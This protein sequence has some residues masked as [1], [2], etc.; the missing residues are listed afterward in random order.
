M[1]VKHMAPLRLL[2]VCTCLALPLGGCLQLAAMQVAGSLVGA[3]LGGGSAGTP[4]GGGA[5]RA[6]RQPDSSIQ[7]SP[8]V[9][10]AA[11]ALEDATAQ[12][13]LA[14]CRARLPQ[15]EPAQLAAQTPIPGAAQAPVPGT[16]PGA[17]PQAAASDAGPASDR[18]GGADL[19]G[20]DLGGAELRGAA[21]LAAEA[22]AAEAG[23]VPV[24]AGGCAERLVCLPGADKPI[25]MRICEMPERL[26]G[27]PL[28]GYVQPD[29]AS[30]E[31]QPPGARATE[32]AH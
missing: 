13:V 25:P 20:A 29:T 7:N 24:A 30:W 18:M 16:G 27:S 9:D 19:G 32:A 31:W 5:G 28:G 26:P 22:R 1:W 2:A 4:A 6:Y 3:A 17:L 15:G 12:G 21:L 11:A 23:I 14:A 10:P 8:R